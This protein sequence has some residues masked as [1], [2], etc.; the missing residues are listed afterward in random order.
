MRLSNLI[1]LAVVLFPSITCT[2]SKNNQQTDSIDYDFKEDSGRNLCEILANWDESIDINFWE[3]LGFSNSSIQD[4][5]SL[6]IIS[7]QPQNQSLDNSLSQNFK[8]SFNAKLDASTISPESVIICEDADP[9]PNKVKV[10]ST[11]DKNLTIDIKY[12]NPVTSLEHL[13]PAAKYSVIIMPEVSGANGETH[14]EPLL[15]SFKTGRS[16]TVT[17]VPQVGNAAIP[18]QCTGDNQSFEISDHYEFTKI[19]ALES[20]EYAYQ[21][22]RT[23]SFGTDTATPNQSK[24]LSRESAK[25][26]QAFL[27][28]QHLKSGELLRIQTDLGNVVNGMIF[29]PKNDKKQ[30]LIYLGGHAD[31]FHSSHKAE[32]YD[33]VL[34][35]G[36]TIIAVPLLLYDEFGAKESYLHPPTQSLVDHHSVELYLE[37]YAVETLGRGAISFYLNFVDTIINKFE[38]EFE[39]V[40]LTGLSAGAGLALLYGAMDR[41][42][43][44]TMPISGYS[45][46]SLW[47]TGYYEYE[48]NTPKIFNFVDISDLGVLASYPKGRVYLPIHNLFDGCCFSGKSHRVYHD[49]TRRQLQELGLADQ[50]EAFFDQTH[51]EHKVSLNAANKIVQTI[52][53]LE[54]TNGN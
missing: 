30:L 44:N 31:H 38:S 29:I 15:T 10:L 35:A 3:G 28:L 41:R 43:D 7:S 18:K 39:G 54:S 26:H 53:K 45:A 42:I 24:I 17:C 5:E 2:K 8:L 22:I 52:F 14:T 20:L 37:D 27:D 46:F 34:E 49:A 11:D 16:Y 9:V 13:K 25:D 19:R 21:S 32:F 36:I 4:T 48:F 23:Y 6:T 40:S 1:M 12:S 51:D 50:F 33:T 47:T